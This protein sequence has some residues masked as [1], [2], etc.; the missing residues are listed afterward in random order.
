MTKLAP[1]GLLRRT[2]NQSGIVRFTSH[3]ATDDVTFSPSATV[4][5]GP[6]HNDL[7]DVPEL[8]S[9]SKTEGLVGGLSGYGNTAVPCGPAGPTNPCAPVAPVSPF[10]PCA[11]CGPAGP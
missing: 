3:A 9:S 11:P 10:G 2:L 4:P 6:T 1:P 8:N 5:F 7:R